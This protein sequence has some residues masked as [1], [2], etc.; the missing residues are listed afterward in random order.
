MDRAPEDTVR[1]SRHDLARD[2]MVWDATGAMFVVFAVITA[3]LWAL[4]PELHHARMLVLA[5]WLLVVA[6]CVLLR[7][8]AGVGDVSSHLLLV[9]VSLSVSI[10]TVVYAPAASAAPL[11]TA[12]F[13]G[14][15]TSVRLVSRGQ[16]VAHQLLAAALLLAPVAVGYHSLGSALCA[17]AVVLSMWQVCAASTVVLERAEAQGRQLEHLVRRD[18]LTGLGNRRLLEERLAYEIQR[19]N[20]GQ[21]LSVI[22]LD[23]NGFKELNDQVGHSAGDDLLRTVARVLEATV[24]TQ[25]TVVRQG[26]DEFCILAPNTDACEAERLGEAVRDA[27]ATITARGCSVTTGLGTATYPADVADCEALLEAADARLRGDKLRPV[28][29]PAHTRAA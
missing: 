12:L 8:P 26:G 2:P 20:G 5:A 19:H 13:I 18:P 11:G 25:D 1:V 29:E 9:A 28:P 3:S 22:A 7:E 21:S 16:I 14:P 10:S 15:L 17:T 24:R 6:L 4:F 27:I 23:L